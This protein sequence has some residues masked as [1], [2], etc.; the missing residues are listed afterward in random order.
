[1]AFRKPQIQTRSILRDGIIIPPTGLELVVADHC[2]ITCRQC[3]HGS[4][5]MAKWNV[6][7]EDVAQG[8]D[9]LGRHY[10]P[11]FVKY[12]G[13]EPLLH[14]DLPSVLHAGRAAGIAGHHLLVTN[15]ILLGR[16]SKEIWPLIDEI[17]VSVYPNSGVTDDTLACHRETAARHG[18]IFTLNHF[19]EFR[20]T[21]T[22]QRT[23]DDVLV[24]Q[25]FRA[26]KPANVWGCH[27]LYKGALYRCPQSAYALQMAGAEGFDGFQLKESPD[28]TARLLAFLNSPTPLASCRYCVGTAGR[29][30]PHA[31]LARAGWKAD[32]D[33][34]AEAMLD[35][36]LL[37]ENLRD[38]VTLDDCKTPDHHRGRTAVKRWLSR[39]G[40][41]PKR[42][43]RARFRRDLG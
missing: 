41:R 4:P 33:E 14:P 25:I 36:A 38:A 2:N 20:R 5:V 32:L 22:R 31:M 40:L 26:C 3:N 16:M 34:P 28:L 42:M 11:A 27:T 13:G 21:F 7:P 23:A 18:V 15:G 1:M 6:R 37:A 43:R 24:D 8:L 39:F 19:T 12:I 9:L 35:H 30:E 10:R 17:E 29:K